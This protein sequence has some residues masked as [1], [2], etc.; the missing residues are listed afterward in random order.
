MNGLY[1]PSLDEEVICAMQ[2]AGFKTL[3]L[4]LGSSSKEQLRRFNRSDVRPAF[5]PGIENSRGL[6][7]KRRRICDL[8]R[9]VSKR[10]RTRFQICCIWLNAEFWPAYP[11]FIRHRAA[12][13]LICA[14][15]WAFCPIIFPACGRAL[16]LYPTQPAGKR[17]LP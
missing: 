5:R 15:N 3:N 12:K 7:F 16:C 4:S 13:I 10:G 14:K 1:P 6:Q 17:P 8:R 11:F 2:F 9:T